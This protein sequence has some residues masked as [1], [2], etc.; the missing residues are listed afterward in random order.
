[1]PTPIHQPVY[2]LPTH[3]HLTFS[4]NSLS[5][6]LA[7]F[8]TNRAFPTLSPFPRSSLP[9][10]PAFRN[11]VTFPFNPGCTQTWSLPYPPTSCLFSFR[12][13]TFQRRHDASYVCLTLDTR[14][15]GDT[16]KGPGYHLPHVKVEPPTGIHSYPAIFSYPDVSTVRSL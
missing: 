3:A 6:T 7:F 16:Y 14:G 2:L 9:N 15:L 12:I 4:P 8:A 10:P 13:S 1:M 11:P 5:L